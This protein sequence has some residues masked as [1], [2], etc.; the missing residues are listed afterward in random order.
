MKTSM[1]LQT[2]P[3]FCMLLLTSEA[4]MEELI[5]V[6][7][8]YIYVGSSEPLHI[9]GQPGGFVGIDWENS[10]P[11]SACV[12][13]SMRKNTTHNITGDILMSGMERSIESL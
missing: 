4:K 11:L 1:P 6:Y 2:V 7:F 12:Y 8:I 13:H 9:H 3:F 5:V 10:L